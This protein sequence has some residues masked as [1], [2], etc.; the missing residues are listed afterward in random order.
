MRRFMASLAVLLGGV[1]TRL[2]GSNPGGEVVV[3]YNTRLPESKAIAEF[4]AQQRQVPKNQIF[5]FALPLT[6]DIP[7]REFRDSLQKPL[8]KTLTDKK[9]WRMGSHVR[10]T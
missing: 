2:H 5:G 7:R 1:T 10:Q 4:Y 3:V 6:E 8:A 9:L